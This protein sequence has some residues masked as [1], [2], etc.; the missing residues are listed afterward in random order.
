MLEDKTLGIYIPEKKT[1]YYIE[2]G[3]NWIGNT[4]DRIKKTLIQRDIIRVNYSS[5]NQNYIMISHRDLKSRY[6]NFQVS[7][8]F[9]SKHVE[10]IYN[11]KRN[12]GKSEGFFKS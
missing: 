3:E 4:I 7:P 2:A 1:F 11:A 5:T 8:I 6:D 9:I 12:N 10:S